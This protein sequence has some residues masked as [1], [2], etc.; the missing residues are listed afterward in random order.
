MKD[1][2]AID[3]GVHVFG[4]A[5]F[6]NKHLIGC[7]IG[8][9]GTY[10][11]PTDEQWVCEYPEQRGKASKVKV[12]DLIDL[13][14]AAGRIVGSRPCEF[15]RPS[16]WKGNID[17]ASH[18]GAMFAKLSSAEHVILAEAAKYCNKDTILDLNDAVCLGLWRVGR[19]V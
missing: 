9:T 16:Q 13:A 14:L 8:E 12:Q 10:G 6:R 1:L 4:W 2:V 11:P 7:G 15:Y 19:L 17:K 18:H 5:R 3:P